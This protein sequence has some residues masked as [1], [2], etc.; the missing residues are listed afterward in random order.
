ML[1]TL[2]VHS[3]QQPDQPVEVEEKEAMGDDNDDGADNNDDNDGDDDNDDDDND[4]DNNDNDNNDNDNDNNNDNNDDDDNDDDDDI[5]EEAEEAEEAAAAESNDVRMLVDE[6][7]EVSAFTL[8]SSEK[9][10]MLE[11]ILR[12]VGSQRLL[13]E[14]L[15]L[16][17]SRRAHPQGWVG[18]P[19]S[20]VYHQGSALPVP[21]TLTP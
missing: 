8:V 15:P 12:T 5:E 3:P 11:R 6:E 2:A 7:L 1:P 17:E 14:L 10:L 18:L 20:A 21:F 19:Q 9:H 4:D 13:R 16:Q